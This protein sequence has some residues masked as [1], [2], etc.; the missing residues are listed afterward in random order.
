MKDKFTR[1]QRSA[2]MARVKSFD[3]AAERKVLSVLRTLR[4]KLRIQP[5]N[6]PGRP[7]FL[8][9]HLKVAIFV[10]GCF[11]HQHDCP[12]GSRQ[13]SSNREYWIPKLART[14]VRDRSNV[15]KLRRS[16]WKVA[17]I[18]ECQLVGRSFA[19]RL[20]RLAA[21]QYRQH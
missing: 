6:V 20:K 12:R 9:S 8:L 18:W 13:P 14:V 11:W 4:V 19:T 17:V 5:K 21:K 10:H 7:D 1:R 15:R 2:V 16:G 3:T